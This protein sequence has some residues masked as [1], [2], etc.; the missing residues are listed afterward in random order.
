M[1]RTKLFEHL[2]MGGAIS[3]HPAIFGAEAAAA[4]IRGVFPKARG[5][6][7]PPWFPQ[8]AGDVRA[9]PDASVE[10]GIRKP[11]VL[12]VGTVEPRKNVLLAGKVV[13]LLRARGRDLRL[14]IVGRR[15][16]S[17]AGEV[18][19]LRKLEAEG[20]ICWP[21]YVTDAQRDSLYTEA[22]A[23]LLPSVYEGFGMPLIEA[24]AAGLP[25]CCSSIPVFNEVA[26]DAAIKLDPA[27]AEEWVDAIGQLLDDPDLV[28]RLKRAG[29]EQAAAYSLGRT[30]EA[31]ALALD[32]RG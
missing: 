16:W 19:A 31:F 20:V 7:V 4:D 25:C 23:L 6:V 26:G 28:S 14:V 11:F 2:L 17:S 5:V 29:R 3:R 32:Q 27:K 22:S 18:A 13:A 10:M 21:G 24:M 1:R 8:Q 9:A 12:V 30:A 15:G